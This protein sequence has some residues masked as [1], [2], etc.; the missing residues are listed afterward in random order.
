MKKYFPIII[1]C[2]IYIVIFTLLL[3]Y[4]VTLHPQDIYVGDAGTYHL[5]AVNIVTH[6]MYSLDG[7]TPYSEREMGM[8]FFLAAIY[9]FVGT[10][11]PLATLFIQGLVYLC[12]VCFFVTELKRHTTKR[13]AHSAFFFLLL[14]P[15]IFHAELTFYRDGL[16][17]SLLL[18]FATAFL[19]FMRRPSWGAASLSG[20]FLGFIIFT[21]LP[22][23]FLPFFLIILFWL[24]ALPRKYLL[25]VLGIPFLIVFFWGMRNFS[26][27][28][29]FRLTNSH[30]TTVMWYARAEQAE[31]V[32]GLEP[33]RCLFAEYISRDW[34]GRSPACSTTSLYHVMWPD[35]RPRADEGQ[36][37]SES[38]R[39]ILRHFPQYLWYSVSE[40]LEYH[41][42]FVNGW[43]RNY[44]ILASLYSVFVF[45]GCALA[46]RS[47]FAA[48]Y[49]FFLLLI[50]YS[51]AVFSLTDAT[52]R[53]QI[54][55]IFCYIFFA[56]VGYDTLMKRLKSS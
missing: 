21:Y 12:S 31:Q 6:G 18:F 29:H 1:G 51:T 8:S 28:G 14:A 43:G 32:Q 45:V 55:T 23:L 52:P 38:Q 9:F 3:L 13:I 4:R 44:N 19:S 50:L 2:G 47:R 41:L 26:H 24:L 10:E 53:Y 16:T 48:H 7:V 54:P 37:A 5:G 20:L 25:A 11:N 30:R 22:F 27:D 35:G 36:I 42:P 15:P 34:S 46:L 56:A 17:L 40:V 49:A 39:K 33:Y